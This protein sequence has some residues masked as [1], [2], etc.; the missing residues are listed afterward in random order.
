MLEP[1]GRSPHC[2]GLV[3]GLSLALV[4]S[5]VA[6]EVPIQATSGTPDPATWIGGTV[7]IQ[8]GGDG[9]PGGAVILFR[10][11]CDEPPPPSGFGRPVDFL[12]LSEEEFEGGAANFV[13]PGVEADVC[14][15]LTG[16]ADRDRDFHYAYGVT[17]QPT[18]GDLS[19]TPRTV[20]TG[21][22]DGE[23][24]AP[25]EG[26]VLRAETVVPLERPAFQLLDLAGVPA[27]PSL[28]IAS[29]GVT[30]SALFKVAALDIRS[31][32]V[33]V[34]TP[35]FTVVMAPDGNGDGLPD[36]LNG[37]GMPDVV[38]PQVLVRR[39]DPNAPSGLEVE[40]P[41]VLLPGVVLSVNPLDPTDAES[42]LTALAAA[43]GIPF[44]GQT[45]LLRSE[46]I[47]AAAPQV[48]TNLEPL[49]LVSLDA[50]YASGGEVT[51]G[52]Q[53]LVMNSTGQLWNLPNELTA[54][55]IDGQ[56]GRLEVLLPADPAGDDDDTGDDDDSG[57]GT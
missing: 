33:D 46:L 8:D 57:G 25:V 28:P 19:I 1:M 14:A 27:N 55:G 56:D 3:A 4:L 42:N 38:W 15:L 13:F 51:G 37:D 9:S 45:P 50:V 41:G 44:D 24:I 22:V 39:L 6:C 53:V 29:I 36:D 40:E 20:Q 34:N 43:Q 31:D 49:E 11:S 35:V 16:F 52:Y 32:L 47:V 10:Y 18:A 12:V 5:A 30:Q 23:Y 17:S 2:R 54:Y 26:V 7:W 48:V 21:I